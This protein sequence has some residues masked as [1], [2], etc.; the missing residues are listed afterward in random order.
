M[1]NSNNSSVFRFFLIFSM[2]FAWISNVFGFTGSKKDS[3]L[4]KRISKAIDMP[5]MLKNN[6][7]LQAI[8]YK[9]FSIIDFAEAI[10]YP[11]KPKLIPVP[12]NSTQFFAP[13]YLISGIKKEMLFP[14]HGFW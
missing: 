8:S 3:F 10:L 1:I 2:N 4:I 7:P 13:Q 12:C 9:K 11:S 14:H 5:D 6:Q